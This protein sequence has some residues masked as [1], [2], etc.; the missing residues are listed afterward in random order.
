MT[1]WSCGTA[2]TASDKSPWT[3]SEPTDYYN[4]VQCHLCPCIT[5]HLCPC[6]EQTPRFGSLI[7]VRRQRRWTIPAAIVYLCSCCAVPPPGGLAV[8][9]INAGPLSEVASERLSWLW[10]RYL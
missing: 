8:S 5:R 10:E 9:Q 7:P 2:P 6:I 3:N 4:P 1:R